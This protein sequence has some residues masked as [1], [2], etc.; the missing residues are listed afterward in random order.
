MSA[1]TKTKNQSTP[2]FKTMMALLL[3]GSSSLS[4]AAELEQTEKSL[5]L[6][7]G[8]TIDLQSEKVKGKFDGDAGINYQAS[9]EELAVRESMDYTAQ[10]QLYIESTLLS[11]KT[12][13][14]ES[15]KLNLI[16]IIK[17]DSRFK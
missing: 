12:D 1:S 17:R 2:F 3:I 7:E 4:Y 8:V 9:I 6:Q 11:L 10:A 16:N 14:T 5:T 13:L 15:V